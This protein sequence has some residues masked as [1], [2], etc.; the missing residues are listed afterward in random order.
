MSFLVY[1]TMKFAQ[2]FGLGFGGA[3]AAH[4]G[5]AQDDGGLGVV[6]QL[7]RHMGAIRQRQ[8]H[9]KMTGNWKGEILE[10]WQWIK[11]LIYNLIHT[12]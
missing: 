9:L 8:G 7:G 10:R 5:A 12:S 6:V 3:H 4:I 11:K 2:K 1:F